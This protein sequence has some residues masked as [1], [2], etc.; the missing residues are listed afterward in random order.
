MESVF[1]FVGVLFD[2]WFSDYDVWNR[3]LKCPQTIKNGGL[4]S[5]KARDHLA[6]WLI[7]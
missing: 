2:W 7:K 4:A 5:R 3:K 6:E 1:N